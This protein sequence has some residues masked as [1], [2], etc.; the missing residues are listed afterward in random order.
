[1]NIVSLHM[2]PQSH[3]AKCGIYYPEGGENLKP[4]HFSEQAEIQ[5]TGMP[6]YLE[7]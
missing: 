4:L 1:M 3:A 5:A 7:A 6:V 2:V